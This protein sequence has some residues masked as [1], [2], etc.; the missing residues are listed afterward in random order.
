MAAR[1]YRPLEF[2]A[3]NANGIERKRY[4]LTKQLQ[5]PHVDVARLSET[6][7]KPHERFRL[8]ASRE[9]YRPGLH[10]RY[11]HLTKA[12]PI[13]KGQTHPPLREDVM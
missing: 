3:F 8:T 1:V 5:D 12:K 11:V 2:I 7:L 6:H 13:H 10:V 9:P 4:K